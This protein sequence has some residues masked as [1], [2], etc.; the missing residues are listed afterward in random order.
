MSTLGFRRR[1]Y[2]ISAA[3]L[4]V[5]VGF[6]IWLFGVSSAF[7]LETLVVEGVKDV[8]PAQVGELAALETG[9]PL[10]SV[11]IG[12]VEARV[13]SLPSVARAQV[14]R[15]WPHTIVITILERDRVGT[16]LVDDKYSIVDST[17]AIFN[18]TKKRPI[19]MPL[20]E[21]PED[22]PSRRAA[23]AVLTALPDD[24]SRQVDKV[25]AQSPDKVV[26]TMRD[27]T[28]VV[29]GGEQES[30]FKADVLRALLAKSKD[31]WIDLRTPNTPTSAQ[32]SPKPAPP[33]I[34]PTPTPTPTPSVGATPNSV[35]SP[36]PPG[37]LP[38]G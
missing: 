32:S 29:W 12:G 6:A 27:G 15:R 28:I 8:T 7:A 24:V 25:M 11:D 13:Q 18:A 37:Y 14:T 19:G 17:G 34:T 16:L 3:F 20:I 10:A 23:I 2:V 31:K 22:G 26:L 35:S 1:T 4:V 5:V 38:A 36:L 21:I 30:A 9:T 33:P